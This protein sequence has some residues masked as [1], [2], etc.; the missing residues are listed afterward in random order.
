M[1]Q[2]TERDKEIYKFIR[3]YFSEHGF[4]PS[5]R[6]IGNAVFM[7]RSAVQRHLL[8]MQELGYLTMTPRTPR[9][10]VIFP[11]ETVE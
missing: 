10:I 6:E 9:S 2:F 4:S 5:I 7:S 3:S 1:K 8:K 11:L